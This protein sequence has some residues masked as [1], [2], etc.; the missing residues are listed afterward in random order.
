MNHHFYWEQPLHS[1]KFALLSLAGIWSKRKPT[2]DRRTCTT[3]DIKWLDAKRRKFDKIDLRTDPEWLDKA[4]DSDS[5]LW[6]VKI[7]IQIKFV[8]LA[9]K[10][11]LTTAIA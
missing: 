4:C 1:T 10:L 11:K 8:D 5:L 7:E 9:I 6:A 3:T 2:Q